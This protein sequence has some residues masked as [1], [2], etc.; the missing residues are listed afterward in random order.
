MAQ[1]FGTVGAASARGG[2][3]GKRRRLRSKQVPPVLL[4]LQWHPPLHPRREALSQLLQAGALSAGCRRGQASLASRSLC[5]VAVIVAAAVAA[6]AVPSG[7]RGLG[8]SVHAHGCHNNNLYS[9][10]SCWRSCR[11][12]GRRQVC[13]APHVLLLHKR[14]GIASLP[15]SPYCCLDSEGGGIARQHVCRSA[16]C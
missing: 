12:C 13:L 14:G 3:D 6:A 10:A 8:S 4:P 7:L 9:S 16:C 5:A 1:I 15:S 2:A 11:G